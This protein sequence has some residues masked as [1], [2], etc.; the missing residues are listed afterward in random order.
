MEAFK[1]PLAP[2]KMDDCLLPDGLGIFAYLKSMHTP[3]LTILMVKGPKG[4]AINFR[5]YGPYVLTHNLPTLH[6]RERETIFDEK[7]L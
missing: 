1:T 2:D 7:L 5:Y 4:A 3:F 6:Y